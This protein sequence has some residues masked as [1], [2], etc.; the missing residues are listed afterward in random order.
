MKTIAICNLGCS[1]NIID[2]EKI[3][4]YLDACNFKIIDIF[5][6]AEIII[7]NTCTFIQ[8]ATEE[9]I[10]SILEMAQYKKT[11]A[12]STLVAAGCFSERYHERVKQQFPE[13]DLW[14]SV[15]D[16]PKE[17]NRYF[18]LK[19]TVSSKRVLLSESATQYLKVSDGC[20][21]RCTFCI[22]PSIRGKFK[23]RSINAILQEAQWL[24]EQG[25]QECIIVSQD[26]SFY[27]RDT[28]Y[29]LQ[30][31]LET[32]L[33]DTGFHW[34]RMMY[35]HP[36]YVDDSF[37]KLVASEKRICS[38][39]DIPLQHI[40][41]PVLKKM[42]RTPSS[43]KK[44]YQLIEHIRSLV[45]GATIR[46][47]F[48]LGFPG[49]NNSNFQQLVRFVEWARFEKVGVFPFS[50]EEGTKAFSMKPQPRMSTVLKRCETLMDVQREISR[51]ICEFK[52]GSKTEVIIDRVSS[53]PDFSFEARTEGDA[54]EIDGR[55][56][57]INGN[58]RPGKFETVRIIDADNFDLFGKII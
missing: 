51:E 33:K 54:P 57:I 26:T 22:I 37:L 38:Y 9:A 56:F 13:V 53:N 31:L 8:A 6:N 14:L 32:L 52:I 44:L 12:C 39:F 46:T 24:N 35:L 49:E 3:T 36:H 5:E 10:D 25:V 40:A 43:P 41:E 17:L 30:K 55:V 50:P 58:S 4:A 34:I 45:P 20:S 23:S 1:K 15:A 18:K 21:H 16:W 2:G 11:G 42:R 19:G 28:G 29:S 7:V 27:G 48:I 47:S